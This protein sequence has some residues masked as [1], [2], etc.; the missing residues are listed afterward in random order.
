LEHPD[1]IR[2]KDLHKRRDLER[3]R[4][5]VEN[6]AQEEQQKEQEEALAKAKLKQKKKKATS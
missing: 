2:I 6:R 3:L 1:V 5:A 4:E